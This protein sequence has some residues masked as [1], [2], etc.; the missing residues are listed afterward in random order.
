MNENQKAK[1]VKKALHLPRGWVRTAVFGEEE[2]RAKLLKKGVIWFAV[3]GCLVSILRGVLVSGAEPLGDLK[4]AALE[5]APETPSAYKALPYSESYG[6]SHKAGKR[7]AKPERF[8]GLEVF[9]RPAVPVP[10]GLLVKAVLVTGAARG[11]VE[12]KVIEDG[13]SQGEVVVRAGS[14]VRGAAT[15]SDDRVVI[16]F[17]KL[18]RGDGTEEPIQAQAYDLEDKTP[19][20]KVSRV[21]REIK[22]F[23]FTGAMNF[24][25]G[26][27][28]GLQDSTVKN[29]VAVRDSFLKNGLLNGVRE[30]ARGEA[31]EI[32]SDLRSKPPAPEVPAET[33][34]YVGFE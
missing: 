22:K 19:G 29:N 21:W 34:F 20:L 30:T 17:G 24:T 32:I 11:P 23:A 28:D 18:R 8:A 27:A 25:A 12:A 13:K 7:I 1:I 26:L 2:E 31:Q 15:T 33:P 16:T 10:A 5:A 14:I 4:L 6:D 9:Q 3:L